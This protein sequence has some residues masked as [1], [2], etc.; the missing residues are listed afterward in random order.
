M[1]GFGNGRKITLENGA[2]ENDESTTHQGNNMVCLT[3]RSWP[4]CMYQ[5]NKVEDG[6]TELRRLLPCL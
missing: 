4:A 3:D 6:M 1:Q 2:F 5:S